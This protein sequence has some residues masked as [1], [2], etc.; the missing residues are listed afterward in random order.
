[1]IAGATGKGSFT[2]NDTGA[3]AA[4]TVP[5]SG[6]ATTREEREINPGILL[7]EFKAAA[8]EETWDNRSEAPADDGEI[9]EGAILDQYARML[10]GI[11]KLPKQLRPAARREAKKWLRDML[12]EL[13]RRKTVER[14]TNHEARRRKMKRHGS[15]ER[16]SLRPGLS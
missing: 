14:Q 11:R 16:N 6:S 15:G 5:P 2:G 13:R 8:E 12:K 10:E 3:G 7:H 1:M 9:G 4:S